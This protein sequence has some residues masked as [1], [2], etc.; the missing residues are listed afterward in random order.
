MTSIIATETFQ[1]NRHDIEIEDTYQWNNKSCNK[2]SLIKTCSQVV[3]ASPCGTGG[4][5]AIGEAPG[6]D[7]DLKG[8][9]FI[10]TAGKTLDKLMA[11][12]GL[13]RSDYGRANICRCRPPENRKPTK[14][15]ME[16]CIPYLANLIKTIKPKVLLAVGGTP[17]NILCGKGSLY[18][19]I[20]SQHP[21]TKQPKAHQELLYAL[22][23]V[24]YIVPMPHTSPLAFNRNAPDGVKW[25]VIA[26]AQVAK[27]VRYCHE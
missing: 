21:W 5:L 11:A 6:A 26:E 15:E 12:Q 27:A 25:S 16:A 24:E 22:S 7:E 20:N 14:S 17:T 3:V 8:E 4:L 1:I 23:H 18:D 13:S 19:I 9:G 10:G 2:C